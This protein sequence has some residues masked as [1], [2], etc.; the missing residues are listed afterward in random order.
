MQKCETAKLMTQRQT[1]RYMG[2]SVR[3]LAI[4]RRK[5]YG[6]VFLKIG[7][8]VMYTREDVAEFYRSTRINPKEMGQ[9]CG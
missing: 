2:R 9:R 6:P 8:A 1:A 5:G 7:G 3:T 4:W